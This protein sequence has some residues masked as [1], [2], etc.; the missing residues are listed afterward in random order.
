MLIHRSKDG[1]RTPPA[2]AAP[3][4]ASA[5]ELRAWVETIAIPRHFYYES[6]EN[7]RV[8]L[9]L[10]ERFREWGYDAGFYG[11]SRNVI[12]TPKGMSG[13]VTL[14]GAHYDSVPGCAGADDNASAVAAMLAAA[15]ACAAA[16]DRP[17]VAFAAFNREEDGLLGSIEFVAETL[18]TL[19]WQV[20]GAHILEMVGYARHEPG[21]QRVPDGLP[22]RLPDTADFLGLLANGKSAA[23]M[24]G[25]IAQA[26]Q[27]FPEWDVLGLEV[28]LGAERFLPVLRRSDH[29]PFWEN[30]IPAVMWT[31]TAEFRNP[32][33]HE[34]TDTPETLDYNFLR[35]VAQL[36]TMCLLET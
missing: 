32:N 16:E 25:I 27:V 15:Q 28:I 7:R 3:E 5:E 6:N 10:V 11:E 8:A 17:P 12:A 2:K 24:K 26:R 18:P 29:V 14:V 23:L 30:R 19:P 1:K 33:Y 35:R 36:L 31:D 13:P 21:S 9:W 34:S 22:I 20:R 4:I